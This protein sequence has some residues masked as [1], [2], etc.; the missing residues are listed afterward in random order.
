MSSK[1][2]LLK[3][4]SYASL[5]SYIPVPEAGR[6]G[7]W[8]STTS[9]SGYVDTCFCQKHNLLFRESVLRSGPL[10]R[11]HHILIVKEHMYIIPRERMFGK[12]SRP[13][14]R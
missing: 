12:N 13:G 10:T 6:P 5:E 4:G 8:A 11:C 1:G 9:P 14:G 2:S 7:P 3:S